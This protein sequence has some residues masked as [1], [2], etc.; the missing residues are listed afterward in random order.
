M[1]E[2]PSVEA[3]TQTLCCLAPICYEKQ[4]FPGRG[5]AWHSGEKTRQPQHLDRPLA[6]ESQVCRAGPGPEDGLCCNVR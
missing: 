2:G 3:I 6:N 5:A 4:P 1:M